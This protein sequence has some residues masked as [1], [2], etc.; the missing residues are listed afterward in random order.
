MKIQKFLALCL[1]FL[2]IT[3]YLSLFTPVY[4]AGGTLSLSPAAGTFNQG[5]SFSLNILLD[6]GGAQSDGTDA[7]LLYDST[8]F[9]ATA[10]N[11]GTIYSDYPGDVIDT[12]NGK[13]TVSGLASI[14]SP[15]TG[16]GTLATVDFTVISN[17]PAGATKVSFDFDP[18]DKAKTTDSNVVERGTVTDI[19]SQVNNG[20]YTIG[21]GTCPGVTPT[22]TPRSGGYYPG[23]VGGPSTPS[24]NPIPTKTPVLPASADV[25]PTLMLTIAGG[26][27]TL[28]GILGVALL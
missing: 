5:C 19:L 25:S 23:G 27:L 4:A 26:V 22:P 6:T 18:N 14:S 8:R 17:A 7:I 3:F 2:L 21:S 12:Q 15:F 13:V 11:N 28:L 24:A 20:T 9:T 1:C 10:I 16:S